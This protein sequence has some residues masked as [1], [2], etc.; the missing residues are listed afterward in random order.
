MS[1]VIYRR[2]GGTTLV[3]MS[4]ESRDISDGGEEKRGEGE[5]EKGARGTR[6]RECRNLWGSIHS[7]DVIGT[8]ISAIV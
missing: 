6:D 5:R 8:S 7:R 1:N 2:V 3:L 4:L